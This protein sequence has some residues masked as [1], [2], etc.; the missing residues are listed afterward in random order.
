MDCHGD[1]AVV[2]NGII[3]NYLEIKEWL[4]GEGHFFRSETDTEVLA[5]LVEH[6]YEGDLEAAVRKTLARV[7]GSYAIV[8]LS[9][10]HPDRL[11]A[12][13]KDS[14]MIVGIGDREYFIAS[15]IRPFSIYN[16]HTYIMEDGKWSPSP[17]TG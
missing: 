16:P 14:P 9:Y 17:R 5:H 1:F 6:Y 4:I 15:D 12:A 11:V 13:R 3:E 10:K 2:H 8:F 7:S